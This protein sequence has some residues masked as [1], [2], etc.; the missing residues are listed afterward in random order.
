MNKYSERFYRTDNKTERWNSFIIR[1]ETTDLFI[2]SAEDLSAIGLKIIEKLRN[3]IRVH[4]NR[5]L[6]FQTSYSPVERLD[7]TPEIVQLMYHASERTNTGPFASVAGAIAQMTGFELMNYT[8]EIIV[9]NGGDIWMSL[10]EPAVVQ[11]HSDNA[12][13]DGKTRLLISPEDTPCG[14]C[15]TSG[16]VG[17]SFSFGK[18]DSV[19]IIGD[20][21]A[22]ADAAATLAGNIVKD[23]D[24]ITKALNHATAVNSVTGAVIIIKNKMGIQG[25]VK[26]INPMEESSDG[27]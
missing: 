18:A 20:C 7:N 19:T 11:V 9:E 24:D 27:I 16:K 8:N 25:S 5:Q 4:I 22:T 23:E 1:N 21:A 6:E 26:L 17:P 10:T 2:R 13:F 14:I 12:E 15:T 3:D